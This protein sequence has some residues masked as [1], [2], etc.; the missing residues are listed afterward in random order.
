MT[1]ARDLIDAALATAMHAMRTTVATTLGITPGALAFLRDMFLNVPLVADWQTIATRR[2]HFVNKNL[3][4]A[5]AG[6]R[7]YDYSPNQQ[8]QRATFGS[9]ANRSSHNNGYGAQNDRGSNPLKSYHQNDSSATFRER[10]SG[11]Q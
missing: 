3:C 1:Q 4:R 6:R 5:N 8:D 9:H 11:F 7:Q 10:R 2:E